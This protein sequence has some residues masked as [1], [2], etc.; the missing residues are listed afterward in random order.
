MNLFKAMYEGKK[1]EMEIKQGKEGLL[2]KYLAFS[3]FLLLYGYKALFMPTK[4]WMQPIVLIFG[5]IFIISL[6]RDLKDEKIEKFS[7]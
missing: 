5:L 3:F 6:V 1:R 7:N 2:P 4:E